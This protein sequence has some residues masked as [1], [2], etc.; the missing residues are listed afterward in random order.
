MRLRLFF[1]LLLFSI[2]SVQAAT[3]NVSGGGSALWDAF[4]AASPGDVLNIQDSLTYSTSGAVGSG[5]N[6]SG[7]VIQAESGQT[8]NIDLGHTVTVNTNFQIGT[9]AGGR[10]TI[11]LNTFFAFAVN[12]TGSGS[13]DLVNLDVVGGTNADC[14]INNAPSAASVA[15]VNITDVDITNF[16]VGDGVIRINHAGA[17]EGTAITSVVNLNSVLIENCNKPFHFNVLNDN[18]GAD[19]SELNFV[20]SQIINASTAMP[21]YG[22]SGTVTLDR[23]WVYDPDG[24]PYYFFLVGDNNITGPPKGSGNLTMTRSALIG[25]NGP[26]IFAVGANTQINV[27]HCDI[28]GKAEMAIQ[29][30]PYGGPP[31]TFDGDISVTNSNILSDAAQGLGGPA[32]VNATVIS[33]YNNVP[34]GYS[35]AW[36]AGANDLD[37]GVE[38]NYMSEFDDLRPMAPSVLTGSSTGGPIGA[39]IWITPGDPGEVPAELALFELE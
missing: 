3:V 9:A 20:T 11:T 10:I 35:G 24:T 13:F 18:G 8:P 31:P 17:A 37:P 7:V 2:A 5:A 22:E 25:S 28:Y 33:D 19:P 39:Y 23:T 6:Q 26:T 4:A 36:T 15:T 34:Q 12:G 16:N 14:L 38:P 29:L 1:C 21:I 32:D 27:D 30:S